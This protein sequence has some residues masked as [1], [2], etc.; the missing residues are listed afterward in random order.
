MRVEGIQRVV[1]RYSMPQMVNARAGASDGG[2]TAAGAA[3]AA[4]AEERRPAARATP[5]VTP[6]TRPRVNR[7]C[8]MGASLGAL[9]LLEIRNRGLFRDHFHR[10]LDQPGDGL[11]AK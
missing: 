2:A 9:L 1:P 4:T 10:G 6:A 11:A 5:R 7:T 8:F 3:S